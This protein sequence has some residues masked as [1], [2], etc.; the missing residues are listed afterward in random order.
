[1]RDSVAVAAPHL[2]AGRPWVGGHTTDLGYGYQWWLPAG[3][4]GDFTAIGVY[5]QFVFVDPASRTTI[6]KLSANR[7]YGMSELES[8]SPRTWPSSARSPGIPTDS[9]KPVEA[10]GWM[11]RR[12]GTGDV[13][14]SVQLPRRTAPVA[15][16]P[17]VTKRLNG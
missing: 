12:A 8:A 4:R 17:E 11:I 16:D 2:K 14:G 5:N 15:E 13:A 1:M 3:F 10:P 6:V 7:R 9:E